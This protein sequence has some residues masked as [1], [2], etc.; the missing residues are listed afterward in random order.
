VFDIKVEREREN[1]GDRV[2]EEPSI[3]KD[4]EAAELF[5][6]I[7]YLTTQSTLTHLLSNRYEDKK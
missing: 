3:Y 5:I 1:K 6:C 2:V 7:Y 4:Q